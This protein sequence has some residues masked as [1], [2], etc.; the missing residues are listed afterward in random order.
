MSTGVTKSGRL[1]VVLVSAVLAGCGGG[2]RPAQPQVTT[3]TTRPVAS[4]GAGTTRSVPPTGAGTPPLAVASTLPVITDAGVTGVATRLGSW[5]L[6]GRTE[7]PGPFS[8]EGLAT[9]TGPG[10]RTEIMYSG[11][12]EVSDPARSGGW[13]HVGDPD[14]W[15]GW[16]IEPF[17]DGPERGTKM[18]QT[19]APDG[20]VTRSVHRTV[21]G[22]EPTNSFAAIDPSGQWMLSAE[23][24]VDDRLLVFPTPILNRT[25]PAGRPLPLAGTVALREPAGYLQG[26]AFQS[27][28]RLVC[29]A[30]SQILQIDLDRPLGP[31]APD[32]ATVTV[33]GPA[34]AAGSCSGRYETEGVDVD[35]RLGLLR[36]AVAPP[37]LCNLLTQVYEYRLDPAG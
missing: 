11:T 25:V 24:G 30:P 37:G 28:T 2:G 35:R 13:T 33:L 10:G 21:A 34:P 4:T 15:E 23:W 6:V 8:D 26:C 9:V 22:E 27:A 36:I 5:S 29:S 16:L 12:I 20:S 17:Q 31:P 3:N 18:F 7:V 1:L 19:R 32:S 14:G